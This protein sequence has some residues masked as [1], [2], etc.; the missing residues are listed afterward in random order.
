MASVLNILENRGLAT[1]T[2]AP[3]PPA[4]DIPRPAG[5]LPPAQDI[6]PPHAG[7]GSSMKKTRISTADGQVLEPGSGKKKAGDSPFDGNEQH[8]DDE[9]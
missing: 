2:E 9:R 4:Q 1:A 8:D 5:S 7:D 6:P 3:L